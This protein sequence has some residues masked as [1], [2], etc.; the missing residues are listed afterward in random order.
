MRIYCG[1]LHAVERIV[2]QRIEHEVAEEPLRVCGDGSRDALFVAMGARDQ[3][4]AM[5]SLPIEFIGPGLR[6]TLR[7]GRWNFPVE[8]RP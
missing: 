7:I 3:G 5:N 6:Q 4:N 8:Q 1:G 2:L